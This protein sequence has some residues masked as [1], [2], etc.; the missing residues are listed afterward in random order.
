MFSFLANHPVL[1]CLLLGI[2]FNYKCLSRPE[3]FSWAD[4]FNPRKGWLCPVIPKRF[5]K[6]CSS[7]RPPGRCFC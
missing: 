3:K 2:F 4:L 1:A 6:V 5:F 7:P